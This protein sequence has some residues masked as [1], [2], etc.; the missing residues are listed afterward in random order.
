MKPSSALGL[1]FA[2]IPALAHEGHGLFGSHW[3]ATDALGFVAVGA[4]L[5]A[6]IWWLKK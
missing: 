6:A 3:H 1:L 2:S 4:A 5:A